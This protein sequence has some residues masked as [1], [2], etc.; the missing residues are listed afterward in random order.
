MFLIRGLIDCVSETIG[1]AASVA[2]EVIY[3]QLKLLLLASTEAAKDEVHQP[4]ETFQ[5]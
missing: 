1:R 2:H 5:P 4:A 3:I